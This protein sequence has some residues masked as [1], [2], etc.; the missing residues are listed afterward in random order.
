MTAAIKAMR[1][2]IEE[3][4]LEHY[5]LPAKEVCNAFLQYAVARDDRLRE[6]SEQDRIDDKT[7][8]IVKRN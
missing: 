2:Q 4:M 3:V 6:S 5:R 1:Q 8:F 7:V